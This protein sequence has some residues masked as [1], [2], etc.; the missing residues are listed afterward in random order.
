M[1]ALYYV[2]HL[3]AE[4]PPSPAATRTHS[5]A[6]SQCAIIMMKYATRD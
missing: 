4:T 5:P 6:N 1:M 2:H 3:C